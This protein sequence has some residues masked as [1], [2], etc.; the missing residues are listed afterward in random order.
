MLRQDAKDYLPARTSDISGM[1]GLNYKR[2]FIKNNKTNWGSCSSLG[3]INLNLHLMRLPDRLIDFVI[4]HELLHTII[5][6]HGSKFKEMM[7][8]SFPDAKQL[9]SELKKYSPLKYN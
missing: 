3:N 1:M 5:P 8:R 4:V 7:N 2:V 6:N 9:N